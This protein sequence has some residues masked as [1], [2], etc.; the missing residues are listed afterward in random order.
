M[1]RFPASLRSSILGEGRLDRVASWLYRR[2]ADDRKLFADGWGEDDAA[3]DER[4][5]RVTEMTPPAPARPT[6]TPWKERRSIRS[7]RGAFPSPEADLPDAIRTVFMRQV[8]PTTGANG[9]SVVLLGAWGDEG[10]AGR[11]AVARRLARH[12][13]SSLLPET[14]FHGRRRLPDPRR[15]G[16]SRAGSPVRTVVE[17]AQMTRA[18]IAEGLALLAHRREAGE[19]TPGVAGFSMGA[20]HA[21]AVAALDPAGPPTLLSAVAYTST[22][23]FLD[24]ALRPFIAWSALG[25]EEAGSARLR[26][27]LGQISLL[28]LPTPARPDRIVL[29]AGRHDRYIDPAAVERLAAAWRVEIGWRPHDHAGLWFFDRRQFADAALR[30]LDARDRADL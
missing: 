3:L 6:W 10:E 18:H 28:R 21:G 30:A 25:G 1:D 11:L 16:R 12:G 29:L 13:V 2:R 15:R 5:A 24:G 20:A 8:E 23:P 19:A 17:F 7:R 9:R 22:V 4:F 14:P 27:L 26:E